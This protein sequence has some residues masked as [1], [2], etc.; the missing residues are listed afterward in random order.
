[1]PGGPEPCEIHFYMGDWY[2]H[3]KWTFLERNVHFELKFIRG[4]PVHAN[5]DILFKTV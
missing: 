4:D 3:E 5:R 2:R 1:M